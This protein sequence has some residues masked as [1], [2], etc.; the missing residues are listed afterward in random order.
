MFQADLTSLFLMCRAVLPDMLERGSGR[1]INIASQ[2]GIEGGVGIAH[3]VAANA[4]VIAMTKSLALEVSSSGVL[5]SVVAPEPIETPL[6]SG[7]T[8][9]WRKKKQTELPLGRF[10]AVEEVAPTVA[11]LASDPGPNSGDVI[12]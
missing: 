3:Y 5:V 7:I 2:L 9:D 11:L 1:I 10:G 12:P 4:G 6:L 8:E